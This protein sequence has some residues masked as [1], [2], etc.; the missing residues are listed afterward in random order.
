VTQKP[1]DRQKIKRMQ[2]LIKMSTRKGRYDQA[3]LDLVKEEL[4][5]DELTEFLNK[6]P[7][8]VCECGC[9]R[10]VAIIRGTD[11]SAN[12][13]KGRWKIKGRP[14]RF[15]HGHSGSHGVQWKPGYKGGYKR[16]RGQPPSNRRES[17]AGITY[18]RLTVLGQAP[19]H[20]YRSSWQVE[21]TCGVVEERDARKIEEGV[22][23]CCRRCLRQQRRQQGEDVGG[24]NKA[25]VCKVC[26]APRDAPLAFCRE[27][28][29]EYRKAKYRKRHKQIKRA[30]FSKKS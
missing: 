20:N 4:A 30:S 29:L 24:R 11:G 1:L 3:N 15:I 21:C 2:R 5:P 14:N 25:L 6:F 9:G 23:W 22:T 26:R 16:K 18:G 19:S 28:W 13:A 17:P 27:H 10:M 7:E 8:L 12:D